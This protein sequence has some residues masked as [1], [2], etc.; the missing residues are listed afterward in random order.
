MLDLSRDAFWNAWLPMEDA[1]GLEQVKIGGRV[2]DMN[3]KRETMGK[4]ALFCGGKAKYPLSVLYNMGWQKAAKSYDSLSGQG[5]MISDRTKRVV[6]YQNYSK[7]CTICQKHATKIKKDKTP[8]IVVVETCL[9][10][11]PR[12]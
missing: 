8:D 3:L 10:Y 12:W 6:E 2:A 11:E 5:L 4:V 9:P 7:A 1:L